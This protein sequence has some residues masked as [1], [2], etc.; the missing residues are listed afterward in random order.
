MIIFRSKIKNHEKFSLYTP[1]LCKYA[2]EL[3]FKDNSTVEEQKNKFILSAVWIDFVVGRNKGHFWVGKKSV[4]SS[5]LLSEPKKWFSKF[6]RYVFLSLSF[7]CLEDNWKL[8]LEDNEQCSWQCFNNIE[9]EANI[10]KIGSVWFIC[11]ICYQFR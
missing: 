1:T 8:I 2:E 9:K 4:S 5:F 11:Y 3:S 10:F 7:L 6:Y